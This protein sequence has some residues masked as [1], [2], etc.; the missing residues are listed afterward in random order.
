MEM[1]INADICA[2]LFDQLDET[3]RFMPGV[4]WRIV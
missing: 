4:G 1:P 2:V 3:R